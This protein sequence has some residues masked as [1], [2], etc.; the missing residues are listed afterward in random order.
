MARRD[1][2][3][4]RRRWLRGLVVLLALAL[5]AGGT[6][7]RWDD[8]RRWFDPDLA[9]HDPAAVEPPPGLDLP[10]PVA[11]RPVADA[12]DDA[13]TPARA[14][15]RRALARGLRDDALG[16]HMVAAVADL[17]SGR[18]V[19]QRGRGRFVP[20]STMKLLT[21]TAALEVLGPDR[22]F[23][24]AVVEGRR[25]HEVVLVGG[26]DPYL[27]AEPVA[28]GE[29]PGP[30]RADIRT[31]ARRT[32]RAL[33]EDGRRRVRLSYDASL[34]T[35]PRENP[36]WRADYVPDGVVTP[37]SA[38]WVDQGTVDAYPGRAA[39]PA[40]VATR[41][42]ARELRRAGIRVRGGIRESPDTDG[43]E[44]ASVESA[45]VGTIAQHVVDVSDN[46]GAEVLAHHVG[47]E[48]S[49]EGSFS[50]GAD[51]VVAT[52]RELGV[53]MQGTEVYDA[54]GLSRHNRLTV[55]SLLSVLRLAASPDHPR[56]REV[57]TGLPVA[58][59]F[60]GSLSTRFDSGA[61]A[62]LGLVRAKTG[63]LTG[64]HGLA[65]ITTDRN[66]N[67]LSFVL[68]ADRVAV[69]DTLDARQGI[70]ELAAALAACACSPGQ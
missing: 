63:T 38:L 25:R 34:F 22:T 57:L 35:G 27:A 47:L 40:R 44:I 21:A 5:V 28:E 41:K 1:R 59:G 18:P 30:V 43:P 20:A 60:T 19:F 32:A 7:W 8:V 50:A 55:A 6:W 54:S 17:D 70:D 12:A 37:I 61:P 36:R 49:G 64:V 39:E 46:E 31:L 16:R 48:D 65:G 67:L 58:G 62:G 69:P 13:A 53:P 56:L 29:Q 11:P 33:S 51:A 26:G 42:F 2:R 52:L 14:R 9:Q 24:T 4:S 15:V 3:H 10:E 66:G 45:T 68:V 23:E